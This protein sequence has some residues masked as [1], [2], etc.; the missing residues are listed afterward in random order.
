MSKVTEQVETLIQPVLE[1][2]NYDLVDVE[3][4]K[5]GRDHYLRIS[6]DKPG[7]VDLNDCTI[8]S[9][10]ISEVM[11]EHDPISEAYFLDVASPGAE[12]PIKKEKDFQNAV[13]KPVFVSLYAPIEGEKEW[14]GILKQVSDTDITIEVKVKAKSKDIT[15]P[16]DKIAK[17]RHAVM[18]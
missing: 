2:L 11:D 10:K 4:A 17:A 8:A 3:F 1:A 13:F 15:I 12:R 18:L 16:R 7:G 5:E 14:L 6:I 9:E